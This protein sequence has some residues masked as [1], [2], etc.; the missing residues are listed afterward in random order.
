MAKKKTMT[1][2][3]AK[4]GFGTGSCCL[5]QGLTR[6]ICLFNFIMMSCS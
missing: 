5:V 4:S 6:F 2:D 1:L 3:D